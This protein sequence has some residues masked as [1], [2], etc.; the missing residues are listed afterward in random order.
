VFLLVPAHPGSPG[1]RAVKQSLLLLSFSTCFG[2]EP[3][4]ISGMGIYRPDALPVSLPTVSK[5]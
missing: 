5:N 2:R 1:Q 4:E 3:L